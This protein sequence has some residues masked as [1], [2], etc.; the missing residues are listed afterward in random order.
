MG[1]CILDSGGLGFRVV[2]RFH[3]AT[4]NLHCGDAASSVVLASGHHAV[5][6]VAWKVM[7]SV[8]HA[9]PDTGNT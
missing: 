6:G 1:F 5:R 2:Q 4:C 3:A 9:Q 8:P 7:T